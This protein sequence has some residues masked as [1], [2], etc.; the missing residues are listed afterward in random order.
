MYETVEKCD[1]KIKKK[2]K[3]STN[4][5]AQMLI[6]SENFVVASWVEPYYHLI[7]IL[8]ILYLMFSSYCIKIISTYTFLTVILIYSMN[9]Y[10]INIQWI[11][12]L[13]KKIE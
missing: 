5:I 3:K 11:A 2:M 13:K 4:L 7:L 8:H 6:K 1:I 9:L 10:L 12:S